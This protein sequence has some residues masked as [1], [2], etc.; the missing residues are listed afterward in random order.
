MN[1][2]EVFNQY[3]YYLPILLFLMVMVSLLTCF[4][5]GIDR[6]KETAI[7]GVLCSAVMIGLNILFLVHLRFGL[8][9]YFLASII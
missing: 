4:A 6:V 5:R 1:I 8:Y 9:G 3:W 7:S 2:L